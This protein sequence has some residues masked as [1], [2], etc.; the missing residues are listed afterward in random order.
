MKFLKEIQEQIQED[1]ISHLEDLLTGEDLDTV[2]Q[3]VVDR[4][5]EKDIESDDLIEELQD[6]GYIRVLWHRRDIEQTAEGIGVILNEDEISFIVDDI[7]RYNDA[8]YGVNWQ[9]IKDRIYDVVNNRE[10]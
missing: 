5:K 1:L 3:I 2:C 10:K 8:E 9:T 6:R 7:E 4:F